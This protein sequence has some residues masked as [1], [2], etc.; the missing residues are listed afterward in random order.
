MAKSDTDAAR[1]MQQ[2]KGNRQK[3]NSSTGCSLHHEPKSG[4]NDGLWKARKTKIPFPDLPTNLVSCD[5]RR[6]VLFTFRRR[7]RTNLRPVRAEPAPR[8]APVPLFVTPWRIGG[9]VS[10]HV[11]GR[12]EE[13]VRSMRTRDGAEA[14][15]N[16][17][18]E[19]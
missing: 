3:L 4:G 1:A 14:Q 10:L 9:L 15:S 19:Q 12:R 13:Q 18:G 5:L 11:Q 7:G 16:A 6:N 8:S 2:A 17:G